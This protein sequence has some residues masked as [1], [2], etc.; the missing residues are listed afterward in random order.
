[1]W[2]VIFVIHKKAR[3][4]SIISAVT[5]HSLVIIQLAAATNKREN[6]GDTWW[7]DKGNH[8]EAIKKGSLSNCN[9]WRG[10]LLSTPGKVFTR[11][12]LNRLQ[13][14]VNQT[15]R[16]GQ[17]GFRKGRLCTEQIFALRNIL[18]QSVEYRKDIVVN[19]IDFKETF[20]SVHRPAL[21]T[22]LKYY[23]IP[24]QYIQIFKAL[25]NKSS[26]CVKMNAGVAEFL[27]IVSG[28]RQ[29]CILSPFLFIIVI[30][31]VMRRAVDQPGLGI[32]WQDGNVWQIL[33][34]L[35]LPWLQRMIVYTK[36][37]QRN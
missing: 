4:K 33:I 2:F 10:I 35:I 34:L 3:K 30:D 15:L 11:V 36:S 6:T 25:Y 21:W 1:M 29:G 9:N 28:V 37:W 32:D 26:C 7:V 13:D 27:E 17:A 22:I 12:M 23:S 19:F 20:D 31:F 18:E 8:C 5:D 16:G 24:D 14:T